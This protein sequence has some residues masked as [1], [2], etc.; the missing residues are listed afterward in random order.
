MQPQFSDL[1]RLS[2][3]LAVLP[4]CVFVA[5][6]ADACH[7]RLSGWCPNGLPF[8][9]CSGWGGLRTLGCFQ[10]LSTG[11]CQNACTPTWS[12]SSPFQYVAR[13]AREPIADPKAEL[14]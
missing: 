4:S 12:P 7:R 11:V 8:Y 2:A 1:G 3:L 14:K 6:E 10:V 5:T 9:A 13:A